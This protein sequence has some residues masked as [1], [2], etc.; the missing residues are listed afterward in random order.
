MLRPM[1]AKPPSGD[2]T[3]EDLY[4]YMTLELNYFTS[5]PE[6]DWVFHDE[7]AVYTFEG[8]ALPA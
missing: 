7:T 8:Q 6:Y 1:I 2:S 3:V 4:E 5:Y